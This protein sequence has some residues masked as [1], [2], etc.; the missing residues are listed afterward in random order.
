MKEIEEDTNKWKDIPCIWIRILVVK[1]F[2]VPEVIYG[3][4]NLQINTILSNLNGIFYRN[5]K[6]NSK[7]CV[8]PQKTPNSQ[9]NFDKEEQNWRHYTAY[10]KL[11]Y[12][13]IGIKQYSIGRKHRAQWNRIESSGKPH[14]SMSI[15]L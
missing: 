10:F 11:F 13:A 15:N 3:K 12:K 14:T 6:H 1:N 7:T 9:S 8:E 2:H 5:G 4:S